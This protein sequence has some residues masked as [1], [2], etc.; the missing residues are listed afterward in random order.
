MIARQSFTATAGASQSKAH[1]STATAMPGRN[2]Q[3]QAGYRERFAQE[4]LGHNRKAVH[5]SYARNA[6]VSLPPLEAYEH[7]HKEKSV[8]I[9]FPRSVKPSALGSEE[10]LA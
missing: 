10:P 3:K 8:L 2:G 1:H 7:K 5:R 4:A 9:P 6:H